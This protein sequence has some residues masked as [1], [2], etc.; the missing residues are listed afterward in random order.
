MKI[1]KIVAAT[2]ATFFAP[3]GAMSIA[4][5]I[6]VVQAPASSLASPSVVLAFPGT[7]G[8]PTAVAPRS[9]TVFIGATYANPR[10][11]VS[12]AG[13][14]GDIVAGYSVGNP[15]DAVSL[16]FGVALTGVAPLGDAGSF[17]LSASRLLQVGGKSATFA[18]VSVS[19]LGAWGVN[20]NR[21]EMFSAYVSHLLGVDVGRFEVP[22]QVT[23][24]Y[25]S[26]STRKG[27]GSGVL[28]DGAFA[29]VGIGISEAASVSLSVNRTQ[30]NVGATWSTP[31]IP[32][33][34]TFG[35][36]DVT[37]NTE[38]RQFSLSVGFAF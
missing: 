10:G 4:Q 13:G 23:V 1:A 7:F 12:G 26:D 32:G 31:G 30:L 35:V 33:S 38:R 36:L 19:N 3:V 16:T 20:A 25:G 18:G 28:E 11:G 2:G 34:A 21:P 27:D 29:G 8:V 17:S 37:D 15:I 5:T 14:D 24:G 9:G 22:V 6:D